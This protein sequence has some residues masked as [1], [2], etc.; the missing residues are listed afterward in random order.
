VSPSAPT[1][2]KKAVELRLIDFVHVQEPISGAPVVCRVLN[3]LPDDAGPHL[4]ATAEQ[5]AALMRHGVTV[6]A[7]IVIVSM[8]VRHAASSAITP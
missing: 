3:V 1:R 5:I 4:V 8:I 7:A 2:R 6:G